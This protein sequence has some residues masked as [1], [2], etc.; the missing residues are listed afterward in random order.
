[1]GAQESRRAQFRWRP[2]MGLQNLISI[3][4]LAGTLAF[5]AHTALAQ[6]ISDRPA[7]GCQAGDERRPPYCEDLKHVIAL[8]STKER[9]GPI[10]GRP[11][12]GNFFETSLT[13]TGWNNCSLYGATTYTC[14]SPAHRTADEADHGQARLLDELKAC[15]GTHGP[16]R[17]RARRRNTSFYTT[18][19][20]P[21]RSR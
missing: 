5:I 3:G 2:D 16:R 18:P 11:R 10:S 13:L 19:H 17:R 9:F 1:M 8:A 15:L 6:S 7:A 4:F 20:A 12:E 21:S 14:D